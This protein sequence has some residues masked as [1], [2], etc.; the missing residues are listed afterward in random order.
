MKRCL[1]LAASAFGLGVLAAS[2]SAQVRAEPL[3]PTP[4][5]I[6]L[7]GGIM[8]PIDN[9]TR[10]FAK[11]WAG[12]G[13]DYTFDRRFLKN[14]DTFISVDYLFKSSSGDRGSMWPVLLGSRFY[15]AD[16]LNYEEGG[17]TYLF[18]GI[19]A[20]FFDAVGSDT[21]VGGKVG[22]GREFGPFI[23]G[24]ATLFLSEQS[25]GGISANSIA[26]YLGYRFP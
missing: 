9:N 11:F 23:F 12:F 19:G 21:R 26:F 4:T 5:G 2:A 24:E 17:R 8:I 16:E 20:V 3:D 22:V 6:S 13:L 14:A 10:D 7:R 25:K 18:A 1:I 15:T